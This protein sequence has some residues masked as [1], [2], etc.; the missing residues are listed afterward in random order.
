MKAAAN[1][2]QTIH[3]QH[4]APCPPRVRRSIFFQ[5]ICGDQ[6]VKRSVFV[7]VTGAALV[8]GCSHSTEPLKF[9]TRT[10]AP[11]RTP[12]PTQQA[13]TS[14]EFVISHM[15]SP[16]ETAKYLHELSKDSKFNPKE[17]SD[18]LQK[19]ASDSNAEVA[20]AAKELADRAQ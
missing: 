3:R 8:A 16:Q 4:T 15:E 7:F 14:P 2:T 13:Q 19:Y 5:L 17:H 10:D 12:T 9:Q 1:S 6:T 20:S 18:M 11:A